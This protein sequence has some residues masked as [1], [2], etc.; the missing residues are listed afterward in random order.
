MG[1][2]LIIRHAL[3]ADLPQL[4]AL[5]RHLD[6]QDKSPALDLAAQRLAEL[7]LLGGSAVLIG[8]AETSVVASCTL[9]VIPNLTR[10]GRAYGLIEN[11]VTDAAFRGR[12]YG[13]QMLQAAVAA[14]W[15]AD[16]YKVMLMT[17]SKKPSTLAFYA[18]AGFEQNKT[19][20][21]IRRLPPR[22][23]TAD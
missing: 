11:V 4:L 17:G 23:E 2:P 18:S 16:C 10:G 19:G 8:L 1:E 22:V 5:Y 12:G 6:P 3:P 7:Q 14:A 15:Q 21:Q 13:K 20:F 9:I